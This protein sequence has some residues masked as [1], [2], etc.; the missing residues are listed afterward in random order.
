MKPNKIEELN[1]SKTP[2]IVFDKELEKLQ[3]VVLFP[4]KLK[5]INEILKTA[6]L[7]KEIPASKFTKS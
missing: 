5:R 2:I 4:K 1:Q 7:P 3:G 6:G